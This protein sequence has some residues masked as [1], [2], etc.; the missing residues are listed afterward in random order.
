MK[1]GSCMA[2]IMAAIVAALFV[3]GG[4]AASADVFV[5]ATIAKTKD[6]T[7]VENVNILKDIDLNVDVTGNPDSAAKANAYINQVN[8]VNRACESCAEKVDLIE[9]SVNN[10][11]GIVTVNQSAGNNNNQANALA[12]SVDISPVGNG[13]V[14]AGYANAQAGVEQENTQNTVNSIHIEFRDSIITGSINDN[15]GIIQVNQTASNE[16]NQAN[17]F[18]GALSIAPGVS[19]SEADLGQVNTDNAPIQERDIFRTAELTGSILR[20]AGVVQVNQTSGN[21]ANQAN[22]SSIGAAVAPPVF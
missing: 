18:A 20:N 8:R 14:D 4:T 16:N 15:L 19:L 1:G 17:S 7:I 6:I 13:V 21:L 22:I 12:V 2:R 3:L 11:G 5:D 10:N 9:N